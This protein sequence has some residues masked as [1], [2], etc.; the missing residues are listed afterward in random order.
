MLWKPSFI[1]S[2]ANEDRCHLNGLAQRDGI[3][4]YAT[5]VAVADAVD[6]WREQRADGGIVIDIQNNE[7]I[8]RGLSMPHSPRLYNDRLWLLNSGTGEF[9]FI[10]QESGRFEA[11][12]FCP[13]Y[14]RGLSFH[15]DYACIGI[16]KPRDASFTGLPLDERLTQKGVS[17]RCGL[18]VVDLKSGQT[19]H[20]V[21]LEGV[22]TE[23]FDLQIL[24]NVERPLALGFKDDTIAQYIVLESGSSS[25]D[26]G[27]LNN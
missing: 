1:S 7:I 21:R 11:V 18:I 6:G 26:H 2:W 3:P 15:G 23:L 14:A 20:W 12:A 24:P 13:G 17:P 16:S 22:F 27:I 8:A 5:A 4:R 19:V 25:E 9:G 10:N